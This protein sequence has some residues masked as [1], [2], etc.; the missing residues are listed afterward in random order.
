MIKV[1]S[2]MSII[3]PDR[4]CYLAGY[5]NRN[6]K[7]KGVHDDLKCVAL[8]IKTGETPV[9][10]CS[11]DILLVYKEMVNS[12][13]AEVSAKHGVDPDNIMIASIHTH[14]GP[15]LRSSR[16][17]VVNECEDSKFFEQYKEFLI[18]KTIET[19]DRCFEQG[20]TDAEAEYRVVNVDGF[21]GC[22]VDAAVAGDKSVALVRF[23]AN[24][25]I[26]GGFVNM[27]CHP[28][29]LGQDNY[30]ISADLL[31]YVCR[32]LAE[33]W[34]VFPVTVQGCCGDM[35]NRHFRKG[36]DFAELERTGEGVFN[37][38]SGGEYKPLTLGEP[39]NTVYNYRDEYDV[40]VDFFKNLS[41]KIEK[42]LESATEFEARKMLQSSLKGIEIR[43]SKP[44]VTVD[45]D[46][47]VHNIGELQ[48]ICLPGELF[49]R[50]GL[51]IKAASAAKLPIIWGYCNDYGGYMPGAEDYGVTY[52][53]TMAMLPKGATEK[54]TAELCGIAG[55]KI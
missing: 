2:A 30:V 39:Q 31:G 33:E 20:F 24:G 40:D 47:S 35:S 21:Y 19:I 46:Y 5:A 36:H 44:H 43:L 53:S 51:E 22:R 41:A 54:I 42:Q 7:S 55:K 48:L 45:L 26:V 4:P 23:V 52:E 9:V 3:T 10:M 1:S 12:I 49:S 50:F 8:V 28:T 38:L 11:L 25:R 18:K 32:K 6:E 29:V 14:A 16:L 37:Q 27:A 34:G 13:K 15:E 17:P